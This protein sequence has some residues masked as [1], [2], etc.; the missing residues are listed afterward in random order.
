MLIGRAAWRVHAGLFVTM[1]TTLGWN[2]ACAAALPGSLTSS[3][4]LFVTLV[5]WLVIKVWPAHVVW[6]ALP[7]VAGL[8]VCGTGAA[9]I[10]RARAGVQGGAHLASPGAGSAPKVIVAQGVRRAAVT[11]PAGLEPA[12]LLGDLR[13]HFVRLQSAWDVGEVDAL[14]ALVTAQMLARL[15]EARPGCGAAANRTDVVTL[16]AELLGFEALGDGYLVTVEF[17]GLIRESVQQG[18]VPFRELWM[19]ARP[20]HDARGWKLAHQQALL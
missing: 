19:L 17:S 4:G 1:A 14:R 18:A 20:Q 10:W 12:R 8:L 2:E 5:G 16:Q 6:G 11:L 13:G 9:W 7:A 15:C 3:V